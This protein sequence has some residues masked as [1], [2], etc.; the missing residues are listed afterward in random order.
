VLLRCFNFIFCTT[1]SVFFCPSLF[2]DPR[3]V[4]L[5]VRRFATNRH[6]RF[7]LS[8]S[9]SRTPGSCTKIRCTDKNSGQ[10][11]NASRFSLGTGFQPRE[12]RGLVT[13]LFFLAR[14]EHNLCANRPNGNQFSRVLRR[15][16]NI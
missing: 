5:S 2:T 1:V 16:V 7:D 4:E 13:V 14:S 11:R 9:T 15:S 8:L 10:V 6:S 12:F 3:V